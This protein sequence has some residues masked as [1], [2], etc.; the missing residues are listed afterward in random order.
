MKEIKCRAV[1]ALRTLLEK[2]QAI[3]SIDIQVVPEKSVDIL[4]HMNVSGHRHTLAC[5][6]NT[7]GQPRHVRI[8]LS[9]LREYVLH[10]KDAALP[11][12]IPIVVGPYLSP[13][14]QAL[15]WSHN[16]GFLD[17]EGNARLMFGAV[18]IERLVDSKP[19]SAR[20]E[21]KSI[22]KPKSAQ[23][24]RVMLHDPQRAWRIAELAEAAD[25]SVGHV[26]NVRAA[27]LVR[28]WAQ[29]T[30]NGLSLTEPDALLDA[31]Q[32]CYEPPQGKRLG[33]YTTLHGSAF[34][35][36]ARHALTAANESGHA[37]FAAFSAAQWLAPYGRSGS[38]FFY[39]DEDGL[40][41]L[42]RGLK[43]TAP[44]KGENV[45]ITLPKDRGLFRDKV[46]PATGAVCTSPLQT[47]LDLAT[48]GERGREAADHLRRERLSWPR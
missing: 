12:P 26:S 39:A 17:L 1:E 30:P 21:F 38:Q 46:E 16:A 13:Q 29:V 19:P 20:R 35:E 40:S 32:E 9:Q 10:H 2:V 48:A 27:L 41:A 18:F 4:V 25:V 45:V 44:S 36:A 37:M 24:L 5:K 14:A 42:Q 15:C 22:F 11:P 23:V 28:E 6:V 34:E 47:Y 3:Q 31:W 43:L 8:T 7:S 33:F